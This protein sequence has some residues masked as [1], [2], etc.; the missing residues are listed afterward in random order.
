MGMQG[1]FLPQVFLWEMWGVVICSGGA[2]N[3]CQIVG[4]WDRKSRERRRQQLVG[5]K[6]GFPIRREKTLS[7]A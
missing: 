3:M 7:S 2:T 4:V 5:V 1:S 6:S